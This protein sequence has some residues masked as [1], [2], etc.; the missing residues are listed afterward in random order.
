MLE[1]RVTDT[2]EQ[3]TKLWKR[4]DFGSE[5]LHIDFYK[6]EKYLNDYKSDLKK[7]LK[8]E[9]FEMMELMLQ[10]LMNSSNPSEFEKIDRL[11]E[12]VYDYRKSTTSHMSKL[13]HCH[14]EELETCKTRKIN[15]RIGRNIQDLAFSKRIK[16]NSEYSLDLEIRSGFRSIDGIIYTLQE[17]P[18]AKMNWR[19]GNT[20]LFR[21]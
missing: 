16:S 4:I 14:I 8:E 15:Y 9:R 11:S 5:S 10:F 20:F 1:P 13:H 19:H 21:L 6:L 7:Y 3:L 18:V 12:L 17:F 2:E